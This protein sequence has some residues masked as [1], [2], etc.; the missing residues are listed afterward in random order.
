MRSP[1]ACGLLALLLLAAACG[2]K[3]MVKDA[4]RDLRF[5]VEIAPV[6]THAAQLTLSAVGSVEAFEIIA[7]TARVAGAVE[8]VSFRE[9]EPTTTDRVLVEIEP[10]RYRLAV[11]SAQAALAKAEAELRDAEGSLT[12]R[13]TVNRDNPGLVRDEDL[14]TARARVASARAELE[15]MRTALALAE[16]NQRDALVRSP[17]AGVIQTREVRTGQY[18]QPG[19]R[20]A[21]LLR[22]DPL[23]LRFRVPEGDAMRLKAGLPVTFTVGE[24]DHSYHAAI[25]L[26]GGS[27]DA[28]S[29]LV[30]VTATIDA[31]DGAALRPGAFAQV[32]VRIGEQSTV[33][34]VPVSAV[35]PSEHG[36][37][38]YVVAEEGGKQIARQRRLRLGLN[39]GEG[40][41]EVR[42][43]LAAGERLVVR[44]AQALSDGCEVAISAEATAPAAAPTPPPPV[45]EKAP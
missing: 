27:A 40:H 30:E 22:R 6:A 16:L 42:D 25:I 38:A 11:A 1:A 9:G 36:F 20:L 12:R 34:M 41:V 4:K 23:L 39:D 35:R 32:L 29:R 10:E 45:P 5:P 8:K 13:E 14:Q 28:A 31:A 26:V 33:P 43:G 7:I 21:T 15:Q 44:G 24:D 19:T 37:I 3:P 2:E 17:L 18:V